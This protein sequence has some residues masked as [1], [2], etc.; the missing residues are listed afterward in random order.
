MR[1]SPVASHF[2]S[3]APPVPTSSNAS[4]RFF[5]FSSCFRQQGDVEVRV[6]R[7]FNTFGPRMHPNDGRVVSNFIIQAIQDKDITIYGEKERD[8]VFSTLWCSRLSL[9]HLFVGVLL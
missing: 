4:F 9:S 5:A 6:A 8:Y 7:I 1:C 3:L 2:P